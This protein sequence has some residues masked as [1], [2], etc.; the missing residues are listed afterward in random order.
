MFPVAG[1]NCPRRRRRRWTACSAAAAGVWRQLLQG[2]RTG[3]H[4][5]R[6][7]S[8]GCRDGGLLHR[9]LRQGPRRVRLSQRHRSRVAVAHRRGYGRS[10]IGHWRL[11]CRGAPACRSAAARTSIVTV[12]CLKR[13][14]RTT[15][16]V[17]A[18]HRGTDRG[19]DPQSGLPSIRVTRRLDPTLFELNAAGALNGH[20]PIT[21][22]LSMI[23]LA[24]AI[25][26]GFDTI[27]MSNEHSA[28]APNIIADGLD[29]N[30]QWSKSFAFEQAFQRY[31]S[32]H[33][34]DGISVF[35]VAAPADR[36]RHRPPFRAPCGLPA[37]I[38]QLQHRIS[39]GGGAATDQLVL[40]LSEVPLRLSGAGAIRAKPQL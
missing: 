33:V 4:P 39:P 20:V 14:E 29:V 30:H 32:R 31:V 8:V 34:V 1:A 26:C 13:A 15:G 38:P 11:H 6:G 27:A 18:W 10:A 22:I 2:V 36:D 25:I 19:H 17:L 16:A 24:C 5:L 9:I 7:V 23:V 35:F 40:R 3:A 37:D 28:S 21:G 12:E